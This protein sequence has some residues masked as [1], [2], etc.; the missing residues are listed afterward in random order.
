MYAMFVRS[1]LIVITTVVWASFFSSGCAK[2]EMPILPSAPGTPT[3]PSVATVSIQGTPQP[4]TDSKSSSPMLV[5]LD[6]ETSASLP[7]VLMLNFK[8]SSRLDAP[9]TKAQILL[10]AGF[11]VLEGNLAWSGN[12]SASETR[13]ISVKV[14][15]KSLGDWEI[16]AN[17]ISGQDPSA[18]FG[19]SAKLYSRVSKEGITVSKNPFGT[20]LP[21]SPASTAVRQPKPNVPIN[22]EMRL[23]QNPVL[24]QPVVLIVTASVVASPL[25]CK[26]SQTLPNN[27]EL[28]S[29][30]T[31]WQ[32]QINVGQTI[33]LQSQIAVKADGNYT[34]AAEILCQDP[35]GNALGRTS[36]LYLQTAGG[37]GRIISTPSVKAVPESATSS[38]KNGNAGFKNQMSPAKPSS[39][40][41]TAKASTAN[42]SAPKSPGSYGG[43]V[44]VY[45]YWK[46]QDKNGA[47]HPVGDAKVEI[48]EADTIGNDLLATV[49]TDNNGYYQATVANQD[50]YL[51]VDIFVKV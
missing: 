51:G 2:N 11:D 29:G 50:V 24:N 19:A 4:V 36:Q 12:L 7:S 21:V 32:G 37:I 40:T 9:N 1:F 31:T 14:V 28:K 38:S 41:K 23:T 13:Q 45:G 25:D 47:N 8:F 42:S 6:Y 33:E 18:V 10:P 22:L 35:K 34:L 26:I 16:V 43:T 5:T 20:P 46:Y 17:A 44:T 49:Y 39:S 3:S 30:N 48:W 15:P 27:I